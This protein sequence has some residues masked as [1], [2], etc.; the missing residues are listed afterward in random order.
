MAQIAR[1]GHAQGHAREAITQLADPLQ[2]AQAAELIAGADRDRPEVER[3]RRWMR[4]SRWR[5]EQQHE[6]EQHE[7]ACHSHSTDTL[8]LDR[9][10][11]IDARPAASTCR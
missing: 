3:A 2:A 11:G 10:G 4:R 7:R 6:D 5:R 8:Q 1:A 9:P